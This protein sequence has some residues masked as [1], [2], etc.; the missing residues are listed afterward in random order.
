VQLFSPEFKISS[1][2]RESLKIH[3]KV[4]RLHKEDKEITGPIHFP[5]EEL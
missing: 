2:R 3:E 1:Q 5:A 4:M